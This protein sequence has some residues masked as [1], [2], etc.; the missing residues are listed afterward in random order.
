M[1]GRGIKGKTVFKS[2]VKKFLYS[3]FSS[4]RV[5]NRNSLLAGLANE[6]N[7]GR[8]NDKKVLQTL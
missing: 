1:D 4:L 3:V 2:C 8:L 5:F 7:T 6:G